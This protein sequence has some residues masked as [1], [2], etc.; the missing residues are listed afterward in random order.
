MDPPASGGHET[1]LPSLS[2][3][4]RGPHQK[5]AT[6][7][8]LIHRVINYLHTKVTWNFLLLHSTDQPATTWSV[9]F[10]ITF[11]MFSLPLYL[12]LLISHYCTPMT[13]PVVLSTIVSAFKRKLCFSSAS[14]LWDPRITFL[15]CYP[16]STTYKVRLK[17]TSAKRWKFHETP[18]SRHQKKALPFS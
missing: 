1:K 10:V 17:L 2:S 8:S 7:L 6:Y 12:H 16:H 11:Q 15:Q 3:C 9:F 13:C 18:F 5:T 4:L 14:A